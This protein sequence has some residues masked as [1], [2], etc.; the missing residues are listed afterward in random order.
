VIY[1]SQKRSEIYIGSTSCLIRQ[2]LLD[3]LR[4]KLRLRMELGTGSNYFSL[5]E[6]K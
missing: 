3:W 4:V 2:G 6:T 5:L 1:K